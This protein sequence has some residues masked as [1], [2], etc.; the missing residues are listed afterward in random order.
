M[1]SAGSLPPVV[2][3]A[4]EIAAIRFRPLWSVEFQCCARSEIRA[5][6]ALN[7]L[8]H[9]QA[10][11]INSGGLSECSQVLLTSPVA[12]EQNDSSL[13]K[14][15]LS[16]PCGGLLA[17]L[18]G[19]LTSKTPLPSLTEISNSTFL[20]ATHARS[21][22]H[23]IVLAGWSEPRR[24]VHTNASTEASR[25]HH[26]RADP[27]LVSE[28]PSSAVMNDPRRVA[29]GVEKRDGHNEAVFID[30]MS[31]GGSSGDVTVVPPVQAVEESAPLVVLLGRPN[32]G[33]STLFNRWAGVVGRSI[34]ESVGEIVGHR[35]L[36]SLG[37]IAV[38]QHLPT[39]SCG[40]HRTVLAPA[41]A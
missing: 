7:L 11:H 21:G 16:W 40:A 33:K 35:F 37:L 27:G 39:T 24:S 2:H 22:S 6:R 34:D 3:H 28:H 30:A 29:R 8:P 10:D 26:D 15:T 38:L 5:L 36:L 23:R 1:L 9:L 19:R 4:A 17:G 41:A 18:S 13:W 20:R 31:E 12:E 32:V 14:N 25:G